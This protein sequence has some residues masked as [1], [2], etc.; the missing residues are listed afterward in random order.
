MYFKLTNIFTN[1]VEYELLPF[2]FCLLTFWGIWCPKNWT[3]CLKY[4]HKIFFIFVFILDSLLC[5][6][7]LIYFILS[8]GTDYFKF[9]NFFFVSACITGVYKSL[10]I[11]RQRR[12]LRQFIMR[13]FKYQWA[14]S[15]EEEENEIH[16]ITDLKIRLV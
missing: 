7:M 4:T 14:K 13:Y 11:M 5:I 12:V 16:A 9:T 15:N 6:E 2:Q 8:I 1:N 10:K 3:F